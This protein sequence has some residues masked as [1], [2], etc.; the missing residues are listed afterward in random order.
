ML[1]GVYAAVDGEVVQG[2]QHKM[3]CLDA[4]LGAG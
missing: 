1:H 3:G 4:E 2:C